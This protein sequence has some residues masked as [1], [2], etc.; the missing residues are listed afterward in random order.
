MDLK[1]IISSYKINTLA[2]LGIL[3]VAILFRFYLTP[4]RYGFDFDPTRDALISIYGA[5]HF[6]FPLVG[7]VSGI[8]PFT[9]GPWYYYQ[10]IFSKIILPFAYAP[11]IYIGIT[12]VISV[13]VMFFIGKEVKGERFGLLLAFL[14]TLSPAEL[15]PITGLSNPNLVSMYASLSLLIFI[16]AL[17]KEIPTWLYLIWGIL[18][19]V[20]INDHFQMIGFLI[21]PIILFIYKYK[22]FSWKS[23][24]FFLI[25]IILTFLPILYFNLTH[26][27][28]TIRGLIYFEKVGKYAVYTPNRWLFYV[29]DFWPNFWSYVTGVP[30]FLGITTL[31][32]SLGL[33]AYSV[34]KQKIKPL[35]LLLFLA[36][37]FNFILLRYFSGPRENYYF[38][39]LHSFVILF[40][41]FSLYY[42]LKNKLLFIPGAVIFSLFLF[43][44][45]KEDFSR[46][47]TEQRFIDLTNQTESIVKSFPNK[48][49]DIYHCG[50]ND[51]NISQAL[52]FFLYNKHLLSENGVKV[53]IIGKDCTQN[54]E[55][56]DKF[57]G[58]ALSGNRN[59]LI[60]GGWFEVTPENVYKEAVEWY[61]K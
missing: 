43:F 8:A 53:G 59:T 22:K 31:I 6:K 16:I 9:F 19:G 5:T 34:Y 40:F 55:I 1:K 57:G 58:V 36:F 42:S 51:R 10:I 33:A 47:H 54:S 50:K 27:W 45:L 46:L 20:G 13:I 12:S 28:H 11:W 35:Y 30:L 60:K 49:I 52:A 48:P 3:L 61:K 32:Y 4:E 24:L 23:L 2:L 44:V 37:L 25:G 38:I 41:G 29:R 56:N 21:M 17:K 26:N 39:Y 7:P 15:G 18:L 14:M